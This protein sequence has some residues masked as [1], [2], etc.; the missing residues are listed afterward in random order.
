MKSMQQE[1]FNQ[2][3]TSII[4]LHPFIP[5]K[6]VPLE[7]FRRDSNHYYEVFCD[8][9]YEFLNF[10]DVQSELK[11]LVYITD[12]PLSSQTNMSLY[13]AE[14]GRIFISPD[15]TDQFPP[16]LRLLST[17]DIDF[18]QDDIIYY[19]DIAL[20]RMENYLSTLS[21]VEETY[22]NGCNNLFYPCFEN[23]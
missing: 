13:M 12:N 19:I 22:K 16:R 14:Y 8:R 23:K 5:K 20:E 11:G 3:I 18:A 9:I 15:S 10:H 7:Y 21:T 17:T 6:A 1:K 2:L 4:R